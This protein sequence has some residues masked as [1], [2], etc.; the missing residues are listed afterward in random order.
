ML[1]GQNKLLEKLNTYS[2]DTLPKSILFLGPTGS[3]RKTIIK[4]LADRLNLEL[5]SISEKITQEKLVEYQQDINKKLYL[6]DLNDFT[7][8]Q[9]NYFLKL[10]EEPSL[11]VYIALIAESEIG[12]LDTI[13]NRCIKYRLEPY[14]KV[15]LQEFEWTTNGKV[16][17]LVYAVAKT[18]GTIIN[19]DVNMV[20]GLYTLCK[21]IVDKLIY[22]TVSNTVSISNRINYKEEYDKYDFKMFFNML[23]YC[24]FEKYLNEQSELA[25]KVYLF[26]SNYIKDLYVKSL[27]KENFVINFLIELKEAI[28]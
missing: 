4:N 15:Q 19:I 25:L 12:I 20:D 11:N 13:L 7:E 17:D 8:K 26:T 22:A 24:A 3:G 2:L 28:S 18:P 27:N 1:I 14:T 16:T 23:Q 5:V 9:Q 6:I 21:N 10:I